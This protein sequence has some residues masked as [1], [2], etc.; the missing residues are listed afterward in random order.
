VMAVLKARV[1]CKVPRQSLQVFACV[2]RQL[3][4]STDGP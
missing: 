1:A 3:G 2:R 4:Q